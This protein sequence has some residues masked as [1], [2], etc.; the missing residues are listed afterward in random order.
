MKMTDP[1]AGEGKAQAGPR[2]PLVPEAKEEVL[3]SKRMRAHPGDA[4]AGVDELPV[5]AAGNV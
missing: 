4:E 1:R 2:T 5:A 3:Q